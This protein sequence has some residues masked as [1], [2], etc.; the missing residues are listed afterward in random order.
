MMMIIILI[1]II[2][3][4]YGDSNTS[5][6]IIHSKHQLGFQQTNIEF[7]SLAIYCSFKTQ[8][9]QAFGENTDRRDLLRP[10]VRGPLIISLDVLV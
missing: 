8:L 1:I 3:C 5:S 6:P 4:C 10:P 2:I 9:Y 7:H